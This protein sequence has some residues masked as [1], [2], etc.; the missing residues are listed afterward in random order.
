MAIWGYRI[1]IFH[2]VNSSLENFYFLK[3]LQYKQGLRIL[4]LIK[5]KQDT[6]K[7]DSYLPGVFQGLG[8][9]HA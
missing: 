3:K 9:S 4:P 2:H 7:V 5:N 6:L 8:F 1:Y